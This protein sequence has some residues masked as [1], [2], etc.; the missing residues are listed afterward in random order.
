MKPFLEPVRHSLDELEEQ[1]LS[2]L[3]DALQTARLARGTVYLAGNGGSASLSS[4]LACDLHHVRDPDAPFRCVCLAANSA[5]ITALA[6]DYGYESIFRLQLEP[7][8]E[9][10]DLLFVISA[11]GNS[12]NLVQAALLARERGVPVVGLLASGGGR[13]RDLC[14]AS[15]VLSTRDAKVAESVFAI[16]IHLITADPAR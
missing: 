5:I 10:R 2:S 12:E 14:S 7:L 8:C 4:H 16:A 15:L 1:G 3:V 13:L 9:P 11:S 6:N